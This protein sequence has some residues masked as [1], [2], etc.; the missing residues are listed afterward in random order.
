MKAIFISAIM[1]L[2]FTSCFAQCDSLPISV[3]VKVDKE[4]VRTYSRKGSWISR[5]IREK[6][7]VV[8]TD[9]VSEKYFDISLEIK[10]S[11]DRAIKIWL[12]TC[13][14]EDNFIVNN[15]YI[16]ISANECDSNF[17]T[18]IEINPGGSKIYMCTLIRSLKLDY[19]CETCGNWPLP[20][21]T[22]L[23]LIVID[24]LYKP[25]LEG[26]EV[27]YFIAMEDKS[28]WKM[29]WSN[30]LSLLGKQPEPRMIPVIE[31]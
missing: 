15:D 8:K 27:N 31:K 20:Q 24:D 12:M 25:G 23:G 3:V 13:S 2:V 16:F 7:Y 4:Y 18:L 9:S 10:N 5:E 19:P 17:P 11:S 29:V 21:E 28:K 6:H 1:L 30:G 26:V 22:K 14:W